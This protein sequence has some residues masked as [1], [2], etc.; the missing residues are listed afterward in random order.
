MFSYCVLNVGSLSLLF[1]QLLSHVA[2]QALLSMG[3]PWQEY[4]SGLLF[5]SPGDLPD[6]GIE[7][8]SPAS[9]ADSLL[10]NHQESPKCW[11]RI[12]KCKQQSWSPSAEKGERTRALGPRKASRTS[13]T[14]AGP[15]SVGC[16]QAEK[17]GTFHAIFC[18][19]GSVHFYSCNT[20]RVF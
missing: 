7:P 18:S 10:L 3:F 4:C 20:E 13:G 5:P 6:S 14:S 1:F 17:A 16:L 12:I 2:L 8:M 19:D 11:I 9:Q 15:V